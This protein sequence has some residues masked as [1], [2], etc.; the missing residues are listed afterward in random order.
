[1]SCLL[2]LP[3]IQIIAFELGTVATGKSKNI[4]IEISVLTGGWGTNLEDGF[5]SS[6]A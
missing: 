3:V 6:E 1:L 5:I 2:F 4:A